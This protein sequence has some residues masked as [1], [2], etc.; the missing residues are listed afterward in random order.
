MKS[1][2]LIAMCLFNL[3]VFSQ[4]NKKVV[5]AFCLHFVEEGIMVLNNKSNNDI[6]YNIDL[7]NIEVD[8]LNNYNADIVFFKF[9]L[10]K[11]KVQSLDDS[12]EVS[13]NSSSCSEYV[14]A[15]NI[16]SYHSYRLKG[17]NGNDLLFLLRD[18]K[19]S[20]S[21]QSSS[22]KILLSLNNLNIGLDFMAIY[23]ALLKLNFEADC[24][25]VCSDGK[26]AHGKVR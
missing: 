25:K 21:S 12:M 17:F 16:Y 7:V 19:N 24:L 10:G 6:L 8:T 4:I 23:K 3:N 15:Y 18:I 26:V 1:L 2:I 22:K 5:T 20:S 9:K 11:N 14:L 13:F